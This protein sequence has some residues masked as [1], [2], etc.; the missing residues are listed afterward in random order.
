MNGI[1]FLRGDA[2]AAARIIKERCNA[3]LDANP[4]L[5]GD[6]IGHLIMNSVKLQVPDA[7]ALQQRKAA[8]F[9]DV[10]VAHLHPAMHPS[11]MTTLVV[12]SSVWKWEGV[13]EGGL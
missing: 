2:D 10:T 13:W 12:R 11:D 1:T 6:L 4:W 7:A 5:A 3:V 9:T 8:C